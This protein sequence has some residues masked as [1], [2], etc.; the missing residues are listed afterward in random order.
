M[1]HCICDDGYELDRTGGNCTGMPVKGLIVLL[2]IE[3]NLFVLNI[4][5]PQI[6]A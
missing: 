2:L 6:S 5:V 4:K 1:F 3:M